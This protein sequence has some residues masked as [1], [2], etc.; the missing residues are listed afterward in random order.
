MLP[1][2]RHHDMAEWENKG[3]DR[4]GNNPR[5]RKSVLFPDIFPEFFNRTLSSAV[6]WIAQCSRQSC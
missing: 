2:S 4:P 1:R 3:S 6:H 5:R